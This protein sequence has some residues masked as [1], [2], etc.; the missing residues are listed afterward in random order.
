MFSL[1]AIG[2]CSYCFRKR[3]EDKTCGSF[4]RVKVQEFLKGG[5]RWVLTHTSKKGSGVNED[6]KATVIR[7]NTRVSRWY[8]G[9]EIMTY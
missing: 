4:S 7:V 9:R 2:Y 8:E 6:V 3:K 5:I 1:L